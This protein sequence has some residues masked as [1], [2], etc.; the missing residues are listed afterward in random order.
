MSVTTA[1]QWVQQ[2]V[3]YALAAG[4]FTE[5]EPD[6]FEFQ[7]H[8]ED[9]THGLIDVDGTG[10]WQIVPL[11]QLDGSVRLRRIGIDTYIGY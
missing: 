11:D 9:A 6:K 7:T 5:V 3:D 2:P 10:N 4:F 8:F 1:R